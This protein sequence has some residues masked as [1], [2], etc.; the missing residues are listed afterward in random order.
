MKRLQ[1]SLTILKK[2][3]RILELPISLGQAP[4]LHKMSLKSVQQ[5]LI[6]PDDQQTHTNEIITSAPSYHG[7]YGIEAYRKKKCILTFLEIKSVL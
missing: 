3:K 2:V 6:Y 4:R 1:N 5:V 7:S